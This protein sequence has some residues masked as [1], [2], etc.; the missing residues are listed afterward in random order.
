MTYRFRI[1]TTFTIFTIFTGGI[2]LAGMT[3]VQAQ[4]LSRDDQNSISSPRALLD[5][6][7]VSCHN[8]TLNTAGLMLDQANISDVGEDPA[9]WERL[10]TKLSLRAMPP[11]GMPLRP[12]EGEYEALL[13]H[14]KTALD[15][16]AESNLDPGRPVLH[17]LNRTEYANAIRDLLAMEI[18]AAALLPQD[19]VAEGFDNN[20]EVLMVSPLLMERYMFA[21]ARIS[22]L[23]VGPAAM[24]PISEVYRISPDFMQGQR[25]SEDL[26]FGSRGGMALQ[27]T[28]PMDGEY[29]LSVKLQRGRNNTIRGLREAHTLDVRVDHESVGTLKVGGE[30]Y[31][32]PPPLFALT[33]EIMYQGDPDQQVYMF[34]GDKDLQLRFPAK[35]GTRLVGVTFLDKGIKPEGIKIPEF[36]LSDFEDYTGGAPAVDSVTITGP[37][38]AKGPGQTATQ[39][40]I[41][42]CRPAPEATAADKQACAR[43]ILS[44]LARQANRRPVTARD[45]EILLALYQQGQDQ[46]E[47]ERGIELALQGILAGPD[48]LFRSERNPQDSVTGKVYP[49]S[50]L[51]LASRLSFFLWST[52]P[53]EALL[54]VAEQGRLREP[55]TLKQEVQRMMASPR[56]EEFIKNF[57]GQWLAVRDMDVP[58]PLMGTFPEF[59][60][61]LRTAFKEEVRLWFGSM[62]REDRSAREILT[63]DYTYVN[64][65][66]ARHYGIPDV[67]GIRFRRVSV[68]QPERQGLLGK[69]GVLMATSFNNR[70]SPVLRGKWV[71]E[72][73][74]NMPPPPPPDDVPALETADDG[75]KALTLKQA[76][77]RHRANPV[78][79]TCHKMMDPIGFALEQ[80][81]AVG[82]FRTHYIEAD[83]EV[84]ASGTMFDGST[85]GSTKEF[86]GVLLQHSDRVV[87]TIVEKLLT[88]ALGRRIESYDQPVVRKIVTQAAV[89]DYTWSSLIQG[90]IESVPFQ[91][92]RVVSQAGDLQRS[93]TG[94]QAPAEDEG[95]YY[96]INRDELGIYDLPQPNR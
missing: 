7:C 86:Q 47:F 94:D 89:E 70:T 39:E 20:A 24:E 72:N 43:T 26:P 73:L 3:G 48:F 87:H 54:R 82:S 95:V 12:T 81:D 36:T 15:R 34:A 9:L 50:D 5:R 41:F 1:F 71:L 17:R 23:A 2:L 84:D 66:L 60:D 32:R 30:V 19:N 44:T 65:R 64:E 11:V 92:R 18:D 42:I 88:Y 4:A 75:G 74:L 13:G 83:A 68:N 16:H 55:D 46:G 51:E 35:A 29:T 8:E 27:H 56:F 57:G 93:P 52:L 31:G 79:A 77:E 90:V 40:K 14:L 62:V 10:V 28:F 58:E 59:D 49:I 61:E 25:M 63:S 67:D 80:F 22:R 69:G 38:Q 76:M 33:A 91:Y 45:M 85:F 6:Y 21:A 96:D 78:C 53:D 37:Y